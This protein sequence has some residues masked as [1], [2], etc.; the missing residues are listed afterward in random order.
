MKSL[1]LIIVCA[2]SLTFAQAQEKRVMVAYFSAT[3]TTET[4]AKAIAEATGGT[5]Y[6]I[7]P[8]TS[9]TS[10]DLNWR[11]EQSRSSREMAN[12]ASRPAMADRNANAQNYDV[13]F[14]GYPIWWDR[15]PSIVNTFIE[16][17]ALDGKTVIPFA[18][19]GSST[20]DNS[21]KVL[22]EQYV[23]INWQN[24]K[25]LNGR[26]SDAARWATEVVKAL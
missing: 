15:C 7:Q 10:A 26:A 9:Y 13:I 23:N 25:L 4:V 17:Y 22:K 20:I 16:S 21:V 2:M 11:N 24:G 8:Q 19:S 18:T 3:G 1:I 6:R 5:L 12:P 14:L